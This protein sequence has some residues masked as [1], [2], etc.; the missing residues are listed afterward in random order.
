MRFLENRVKGTQGILVLSLT[1]N[2]SF[3]MFLVRVN[4]LLPETSLGLAAVYEKSA[5][6]VRKTPQP[7][8]S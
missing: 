2:Q 7:Q 5:E 6:G 4:S 8:S 1:E 3:L